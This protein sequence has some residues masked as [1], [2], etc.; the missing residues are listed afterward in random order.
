MT[1]AIGTEADVGAAKSA[2]KSE[3]ALTEDH[4]YKVSGRNYRF[5]LPNANGVSHVLVPKSASGT[6]VLN[7]SHPLRQ[8]MGTF[9][10]EN[11]TLSITFENGLKTVISQDGTQNSLNDSGFMTSLAE[12]H[13]ILSSLDRGPTGL[14]TGSSWH[15]GKNV[16]F[17]VISASGDRI[18]F[19]KGRFLPG[20]LDKTWDDIDI[21]T[22]TD[23]RIK[24]MQRVFASPSD[25]ILSR[26]VILWFK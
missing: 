12:V 7:A 6:L 14:A 15:L 18:F 1:V 26:R 8:T 2:E 21:R 17:T 23:G 4:Q 20:D 9:A 24:Q 16:A 11:G 13:L 22:E 3:G 5:S 25:A 10:W 19:D